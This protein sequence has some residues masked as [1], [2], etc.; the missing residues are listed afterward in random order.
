M[1]KWD[2][3][4]KYYTRYTPGNDRFEAKVLDTLAQS[5]ID[6]T[7]K[8]II[9]IGCGTGV[10]T[11]RIAAHAAHVDALDSSQGMLEVLRQDAQKLHLNNITIL[12]EP[13]RTF[14]VSP[15][16]YDLALCTMSPALDEPQDFMKMTQCAK[17]KVYLGWAG[18]RSSQILEAL[19]QAHQAT[20]S[21]PNGAGKLATWLEEQKIAYTCIPFDENRETI[22]D[23]DTAFQSFIWHL[24]VRGVTPDKQKV[25]TVLEQFCDSDGNVTEKMMNKMNLILW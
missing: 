14:L 22:K 5:K 13:W 25:K 19:F 1:S 11:L 18:R 20:Y 2:E 15:N 6:I 23:F 17:T 16:S 12:P 24:E 9:D 10:Y 7:N 8:K 21:H 3:K 4:A